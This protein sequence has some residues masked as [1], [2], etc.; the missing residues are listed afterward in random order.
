MATQ[1]LYGGS[2][3]P[4]STYLYYRT[5][6]LRTPLRSQWSA[7]YMII[8]NLSLPSHQAAKWRSKRNGSQSVTKTNPT[9]PESVMVTHTHSLK[10][11]VRPLRLSLPG[12]VPQWS[13]RV[14]PQPTQL[15]I[16]VYLEPRFPFSWQ[17]NRKS[18]AIVSCAFTIGSIIDGT[19]KNG[20][21]GRDIVD[22]GDTF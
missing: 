12:Q 18:C 6:C 22:P 3:L 14:F 5:R 16:I 9:S 17:S 13:I 1:A 19:F 7:R 2:S 21:P 10:N 11:Q 4:T 15:I 8:M 20:N